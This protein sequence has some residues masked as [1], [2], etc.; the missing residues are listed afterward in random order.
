[1]TMWGMEPAL[2]TPTKCH[3]KSFHMVRGNKSRT[4]K[5][6]KKLYSEQ[7]GIQKIGMVSM[8]QE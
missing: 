4:L 5:K 6:R 2:P 1:M 7:M 3:S 8:D